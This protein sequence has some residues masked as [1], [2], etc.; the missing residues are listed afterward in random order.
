VH[1]GVAVVSQTLDLILYQQLFPLELYDFQ[2]IDRGVGQAIVDFFFKCLMLFLEFRKV[3]LHRHAACL[4]NQ[5]LPDELSLAQ[6]Q[7]KGDVTPGFAPQQTVRKPLIG[8]DFSSRLDAL[9]ENVIIIGLRLS[10]MSG[11]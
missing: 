7:Y 1:A 11:R 2:V 6:T 4:L 9:V 3:R 10:P 8:G 5:W